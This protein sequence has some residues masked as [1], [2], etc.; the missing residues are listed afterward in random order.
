MLCIHAFIYWRTCGLFLV[1]NAAMNIVYKYLFESQP[2]I[3]YGIHTKV[4]LLL[5]FNFLRNHH[6]IFHSSYNIVVPTRNA[7]GF[8]FLHILITTYNF[9]NN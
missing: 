1:N 3:L 9:L 2:L 4:E 7:K 8:Q 5:L 6:T